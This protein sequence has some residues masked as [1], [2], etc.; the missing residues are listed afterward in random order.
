MDDR[1]EPLKAMTPQYCVLMAW[2]VV[3]SITKRFS[4]ER[5]ILHWCAGIRINIY[6]LLLGITLSQLIHL[7]N[8]P[9][10]KVQGPL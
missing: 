10:P 8:T 2:F 6:R 4:G 9:T 1:L 5:W 7:Q 3:F